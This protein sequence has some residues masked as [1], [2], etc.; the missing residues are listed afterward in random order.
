MLFNKACFFFV[1]PFLPSNG[2][3]SAWDPCVLSERCCLLCVFLQESKPEKEE[4]KNKESV[5][6]DEAKK[7]RFCM[8]D[9]NFCIPILFNNRSVVSL[10][11]FFFPPFFAFLSISSCVFSFKLFLLLGVTVLFFLDAF[12][13]FLPT[14]RWALSTTSLSPPLTSPARLLSR[15]MTRRPSMKHSMTWTFAKAFSS[16]SDV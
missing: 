6:D 10:L 12:S 7:V 3:W 11:S 16:L 5:T 15:R 9:K 4:R 14:S 8:E 2:A 13:V 1:G